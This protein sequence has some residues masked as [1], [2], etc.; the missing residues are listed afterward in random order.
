[1]FTLLTID[2]VKKKK[3]NCFYLPKKE[4]K[5]NLLVHLNKIER[6]MYPWELKYAEDFMTEMVK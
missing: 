2:N 1:M 5:L 6:K 3:N 4:E